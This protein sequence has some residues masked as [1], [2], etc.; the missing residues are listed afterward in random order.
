MGVFYTGKA[1]I[2][3]ESGFLRG[4][5]EYVFGIFGKNGKRK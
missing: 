5:I 1:L 3:L 4:S 2:W